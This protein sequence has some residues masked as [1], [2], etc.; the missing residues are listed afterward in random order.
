VSQ[1]RGDILGVI[2]AGGQAARMGGSDKGWIAYRGRA[3]IETAL[4]RL[5]PQVGAV[6]ICANRNL[7]R[8]R[9]LGVAVF[10]DSPLG[11]E[12]YAGP[13]AG[14]CSGLR[15]ADRRWVA[16]VP[17]DAPRLPLD[18][19]SRLA[20]ALP[21]RGASAS[22][23]PA[24]GR[25]VDAHPLVAFASVGG[26]AEPCFALLARDLHDELDAALRRGIRRIDRFYAQV[27][28]VSVRFDDPGA[29][30]NLNT[31][32]DLEQDEWR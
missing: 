14:I 7:E 12:P 8:Y 21:G 11:L 19:V 18:L 10:D 20:A 3:L 28:A 31:P 29:F 23:A 6:A 30:V 15:Q 5:R 4:E 2:L 13:L 26:T 27:D 9:A 32:A 25:P 22:R 16:V 24:D 17:C 1:S